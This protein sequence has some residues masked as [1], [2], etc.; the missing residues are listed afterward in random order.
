M[1]RLLAEAT[2]GECRINPGSYGQRIFKV[3]ACKLREEF[4]PLPPWLKARHGFD[5]LLTRQPT[6]VQYKVP[7]FGWSSTRYHM[8]I[9]FINPTIEFLSGGASKQ[10]LVCHFDANDNPDPIILDYWRET[11]YGGGATCVINAGEEWSKVIGPIFI[12]CN[13][14]TNPTPSCNYCR[15]V[16]RRTGQE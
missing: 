14:L 7:A 4:V 8:G 16:L 10:E 9:W 12:Y 1:V 3:T 2:A 13:A 11:H 15:T 6:A 5:D